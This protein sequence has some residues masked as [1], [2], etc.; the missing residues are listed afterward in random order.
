MRMRSTYSMSGTMTNPPPT[1]MSAARTPPTAPSVT[2]T[3][4]ETSISDLGKRIRP[5]S[6]SSQVRLGTGSN[7]RSDM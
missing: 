7:L 1:P 5:G 2:G 3:R 4:K 6:A